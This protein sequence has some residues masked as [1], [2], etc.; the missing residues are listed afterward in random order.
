MIAALIL[1]LIAGA[2]ARFIF[3]GKENMGWL[4]TIAL[5]VVGSLLATILGQAVGWY[6][7][8][9]GAGL[10]GS[11]VGALIVLF[12]YNRVVAGK[13]PGDAMQASNNN[14]STPS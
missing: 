1:G 3:P 14:G 11:V 8:G 6:K 5:G 2:V 7:G 10:I 4:L 9:Q 12:V 13:K